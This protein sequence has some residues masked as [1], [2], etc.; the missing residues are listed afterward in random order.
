[1]NNLLSLSNC[2]IRN[3]PLGEPDNQ[4]P[5]NYLLINDSVNL[6]QIPSHVKLV[7]KPNND[8]LP[9]AGNPGYYAVRADDF[10]I[11]SLLNT[12]GSHVQFSNN[13]Y[14]VGGT[15]VKE[16]R[17]WEFQY[18][19]ETSSNFAT[20]NDPASVTQYA[21]SMAT[22]TAIGDLYAQYNLSTNQTEDPIV[23]GNFGLNWTPYGTIQNEKSINEFGQIG[24]SN[25]G[26][27]Y[28]FSGLNTNQ[29]IRDY[30]SDWTYDNLT[31]VP[32]EVGNGG[33]NIYE[34]S[35]LITSYWQEFN[36][37]VSSDVNSVEGLMLVLDS[38]SAEGFPD[39]YA[40][41]ESMI[42]P[43]YLDS[44][45]N[46]NLPVMDET[47]LAY[48]NDDLDYSLR[49]Y[50]TNTSWTYINRIMIC[51]SMENLGPTSSDANY[52]EDNEVHVW[53]ELKDDYILSDAASTNPEM[54]N[55][56]VDIQGNAKYIET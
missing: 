35:W 6:N 52:H 51:D 8:V 36:V 29:L 46:F 55:L 15:T 13:L 28:H 4:N 34:F 11:G 53:I 16:T 33:G 26:R 56:K 27:I 17:F 32:T 41:Y 39:G 5:E 31:T 2:K 40:T 54:W 44:I 49:S 42:N 24:N 19:I 50:R 21:A 47:S 14:L 38:M 12:L 23:S 30:G 45:G 43:V 7:I 18:T 1:M 3:Y 22:Q 9:V 25:M 48:T 37:I 10:S 20:S